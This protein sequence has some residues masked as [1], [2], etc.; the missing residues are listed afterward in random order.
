VT[1]NPREPIPIIRRLLELPAGDAVVPLRD[2][3]DH[4]A[5]DVSHGLIAR[6]RKYVDGDTAGAVEREVALLHVLS[7][8]SPIPVPE[9]VA[10]DPAAGVV[11]FRRLPGISLFDRPPSDPLAFADPLAR[12]VHSLHGVSPDVVE[13]LVGRDEYPLAACL[14]DAAD[15]MTGVAAHLTTAQQGRLERFLAGPVPPESRERT[16][17]HNDLGAEHVL[18]SE[19]GS[20]LTGVIDWSDAAIADPA[21]DVGRLLRDFGFGLAGVVLRRTGGDDSTLRRAVFYARCALLGDLAYGIET[22]RPQYVAHALG[23]FPTTFPRDQSDDSVP[24]S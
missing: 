11:V 12:F 4:W 3:S 9:V 19:D 20:G 21:R 17:C 16:L 15:H 5:F 18:V 10:A 14:S 2:G 8:V 1:S 22:S 13:P 24:G 23:R 7:R 6:V